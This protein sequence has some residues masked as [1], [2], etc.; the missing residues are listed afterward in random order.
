MTPETRGS[1]SPSPVHHPELNSEVA[2]LSNKLITAINH[3]TDLDDS[4]AATRHELE[5]S[6]EQIR[7][8]EA[9]NKEYA[10]AV[11]NGTLVNKSDV[12][13]E[14]SKLRDAAE[15]E[16]NA[17]SVA[18]KARKKIELE[19]ETLTAALFEEANQVRTF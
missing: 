6:R 16:R 13:E 3:Q 7:Q 11:S 4:L 17:R 19:V 5:H 12:D 10:E 14:L 15:E 2:T 18:D 1:E 8:L 9:S